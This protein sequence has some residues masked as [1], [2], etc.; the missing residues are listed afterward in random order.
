MNLSQQAAAKY[1]TAI[2]PDCI[3]F[4][5][6][7]L[8]CQGPADGHNAV[9]VLPKCVC[10]LQ[11]AQ[12]QGFRGVLPQV[13]LLTQVACIRNQL[14]DIG[15]CATVMVYMHVKAFRHKSCNYR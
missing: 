10:M 11:V 6:F 15:C 12:L 7:E 13:L 14:I 9:V 2:S 1:G 3:N 8:C 5:G 4:Q